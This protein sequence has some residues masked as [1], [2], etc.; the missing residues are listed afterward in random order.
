MTCHPAQGRLPADRQ[1]KGGRDAGSR[2]D[3]YQPWI[4]A[5]AGMTK[6]EW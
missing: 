4:P 1:G 6:T 5:F 3:P 2:V